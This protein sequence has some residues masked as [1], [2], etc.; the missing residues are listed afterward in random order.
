MRISLLKSEER[1]SWSWREELEGIVGENS[2]SWRLVRMSE[3]IAM[4]ANTEADEL[5][6]VIVDSV[7]QDKIRFDMAIA[8]SC[9]V[10]A[11][12]MV[13]KGWRKRLSGAE[14]INDG[15]YLLQAFPASQGAFKV[16]GELFLENAHQHGNQ[17]SMANAALSIS[18]VLSNGPYDGSSPAM[19]RS[20]TA[21]VVAFG[22]S[23]PS[24]ITIWHGKPRC[25][26]VCMRSMFMAVEVVMPRR[27]KRRSACFLISGLTRNAIV[28]EFVDICLLLFD[29]CE[30]YSISCGQ[31]QA[32]AVDF[33]HVEHVEHVEMGKYKEAA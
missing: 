4:R 10:A 26:I 31:K 33:N 16:A 9:I 25:S 6:L 13:A 22:M 11:K 15:C 14:Q 30:Q 23:F 29:N 32:G 17:S 24:L 18:F 12:R 7:Y 21:R 3:Q 20:R 8:V 5:Q 19:S 28:A 2:W 27:S 1:K